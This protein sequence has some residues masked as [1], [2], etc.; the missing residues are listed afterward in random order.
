MK[1]HF[2]DTKTNIGGKMFGSLQE[3]YDRLRDIIDCSHDGIFITDGNA[4]VLW[5]NPAYYKI[6]GLTMR[7][8]EN[9]N[10]YNLVQEHIISESGTLL[11]IKKRETVT[12]E[13]TFQTG[14]RAL[15][16][17]T[18][19]FGELDE[20]VMV[21]TNVRD[22]TDYYELQEKYRET[23]ER[24]ES[25]LEFTRKRIFESSELIAKD[26][27]TLNVLRQV[28]KVAV[29]D[30]TVLLRGETGVGKENFAKHIF[31][32]SPRSKEQFFSINCGAI[33]S[34]LI[35]SELF[36]YE[37]G[38]FTGATKD[39]MGIFELADKG[40]LFLDE[41]GD[42]PSDMQVKLLRVLQER[43]VRR[44]G[45]QKDIPFDVRVITAT[46][47]DLEKMVENDTF[48]KDLF[49]RLNVVPIHIPPLRERKGDIIPLAENF[50]NE[51]NKKYNFNKKFALSARQELETYNWPGNI[52]ELRNVVER[53]VVLSQ[54]KYIYA[55]DLPFHVKRESYKA[56]VKENRAFDLKYEVMKFEYNYMEKAYAQYN[57]VRDAAA[58]LNMDAS[59]F[60]RKRQKYMETVAK[61]HHDA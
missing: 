23:Q 37:K 31:H 58:S 22:I 55:T 61:M 9:K 11:A 7:D 8:V 30:T 15:I 53:V 20:I 10:M 16:S 21:V 57:N 35:E 29:L 3:A 18:P 59:T 54:D 13:Q 33:P 51:L 17:S 26:P 25:E 6:S 45:G 52:R 41:I 5:V 60:V 32:I 12:L 34:N 24:Y 44:I 48:R 19:C 38:S 4:N 46:N 1:E 43:T 2:L 47:R 40:T 14:K 27:V 56:F 50:L 49:Y 42:L 36:G 39:K 28:E